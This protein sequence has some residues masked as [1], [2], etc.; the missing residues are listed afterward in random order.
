MIQLNVKTTYIYKQLFTS[1]NLI[2]L[3]NGNPSC[4]LNFKSTNNK[5][6]NKKKN[7]KSR[8]RGSNI[9][10]VILSQVFCESDKFKTSWGDE[11]WYQWWQLVVIKAP[12]NFSEWWTITLIIASLFYFIFLIHCTVWHW[13]MFSCE[14]YTLY[15]FSNNNAKM[16]Q[17]FKLLFRTFW[18][19]PTPIKTDWLITQSSS[20]LWLPA[21]HSRE[22]SYLFIYFVRNLK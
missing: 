17:S 2:P 5:K 1:T 7:F 6:N 3:S 21:D 15:L 19:K 16:P 20:H 22:Y 18:R 4:V 13:K 9:H 14:K 11:N 8:T 10:Y 12:S